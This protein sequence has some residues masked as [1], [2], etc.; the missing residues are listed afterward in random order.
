MFSLISKQSLGFVEVNSQM[1]NLN[2]T[3]GFT[4]TTMT[5]NSQ[6]S[7]TESAVFMYASTYTRNQEK[8]QYNMARYTCTRE[9]QRGIT[10]KRLNA[11]KYF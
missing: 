9:K 4:S 11:S 7:S 3:I 2:L 1:Q 5:L 6:N 10:T 8:Q